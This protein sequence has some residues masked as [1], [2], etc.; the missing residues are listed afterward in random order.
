MAENTDIRNRMEGRRTELS[1]RRQTLHTEIDEIDAELRAINA[2]FAALE[3]RPQ[4]RQRSDRTA[5]NGE[6]HP[7]GFVQQTVLKTITEHPQGLTTAELIVLLKPLNVGQQSISSALGALRE[8]NKII[9]GGR[10]GKHRPAAARGPH[11]AGSAELVTF[12]QPERAGFGLTVYV[13]P[14]P[15]AYAIIVYANKPEKRRYPRILPQ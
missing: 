9:F 11:C 4:A 15:H 8:G 7:R 1:D 3:E 5:Q 13:D 10:G 14:L 6:R 12:L 2:Y